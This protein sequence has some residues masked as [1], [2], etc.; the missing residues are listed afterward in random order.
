MRDNEIKKYFQGTLGT[1]TKLNFQ[2]TEYTTPGACSKYMDEYEIGDNLGTGG[3]A[4][5]RKTLHKPTSFQ[6]AVKIYEKYKLID[7]QVK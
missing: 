5:V 3:F 6:V 4:T 7:V 1:A 2:N